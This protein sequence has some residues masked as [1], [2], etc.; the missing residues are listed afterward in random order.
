[1][2]TEVSIEL[3]TGAFVLAGVVFG[4][5]IQ[6]F[7]TN[8]R[9]RR[10][11]FEQRQSEAYVAFLKATAELAIAQTRDQGS[12]SLPAAMAAAAEAKAR[13]AIYGNADV[14]KRLAHFMRKHEALTSPEAMADFVAVATAMRKSSRRAKNAIPASDLGQLLFSADVPD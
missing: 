14:A 8:I 12:A 6:F 2:P 13:I 5:L 1:M 11:A 9:T 3:I 7:L 4:A 10:E